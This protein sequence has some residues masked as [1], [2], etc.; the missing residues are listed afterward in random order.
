MLSAKY[1][2]ENIDG[3]KASM[4]KRHWEYDIDGILKLDEQW[5]AVQTETQK[6]QAQRNKSSL[7]ISEMKKKGKNEEVEVIRKE[8]VEVKEKI[9]ANEARIGELDAGLN[10]LLWNMPN[11]LHQSVPYGKD[12]AENPVVRTFMDAKKRSIPGH[13]EIA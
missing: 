12:D 13:E 7:E 8:L 2:R 6:L 5:R 1:V 4:A 11:I 3:I 10:K 9:A